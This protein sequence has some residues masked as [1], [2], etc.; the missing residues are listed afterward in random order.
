VGFIF[1][2]R[3]AGYASMFILFRKV[4]NR[5]DLRLGRVFQNGKQ[6]VCLGV[7]RFFRVKV[8]KSC[9]RTTFAVPSKSKL[10]IL[11]LIFCF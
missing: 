9:D 7:S 5:A 10:Q 4:G 3:W 11:V 2:L 1:L 6:A 8:V